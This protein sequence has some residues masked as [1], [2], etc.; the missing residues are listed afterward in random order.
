MKRRTAIRN[1]V[2]V[3]A[4][5]A[6]LYACENKATIALKHIPLTGAEEDLLTELTETIIPKTEFPG[7]K[8][9]KTA[10][11][12]FM[13]ADDCLS[14]DDQAKF[15]AGMKAFDNVCKSKMGSRFVKL[16]KEKRY[17]YLGMIETDKEG[18]EVGQDVR[19][20]YRSVKRGTLDNFT[21]SQEFLAQVRNVTTLI[22]PRFVA[23]A[24]VNS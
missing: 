5:A 6:F 19:S 11:F 21:S 15:S 14:P 16:S 7:A 13:M 12:I 18:K 9:L 23:C 3:S 24:P 1:A 8:D 22:P 10:D 2:L 4:G 17:E 20:F